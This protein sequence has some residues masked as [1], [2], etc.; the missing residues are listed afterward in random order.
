MKPS[1]PPLRDNGLTPPTRGLRAAAPGLSRFTGGVLEGLARQTRFVDPELIARWTA[2][3]GPEISKLCRPGRMTGGRAG[4]TLEVIVPHG[5]A[6]ASV[7]FAAETLRRRLNDY[8]GP[9]TII[10]I[11]VIQGAAPK[12]F[13]A[14]GDTPSPTGPQARPGGLSRFRTGG[15]R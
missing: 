12:P 10:K 8:F 7:E 9:D 5:A 6:A 2:L 15:S 14:G 3:A 1:R 4:R 11:A 13:P